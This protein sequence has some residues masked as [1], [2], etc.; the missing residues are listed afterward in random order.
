MK[1]EAC[2]TRDRWH[3][4]PAIL[5]VCLAT[6]CAPK[7][8]VV[9]ENAAAQ[10]DAYDEFAL[11]GTHNLLTHDEATNPDGTVNVVVEIPAGTTAKWEV[12]KEDGMLRWEFRDGKPRRVAYLA[13]PANYGMIPRTLLPE[14]EGGDGDPLDAVVLGPALSRGSIA[15]G[16]LIGV[17]KL[18]DGG[19][20]DDKLVVA[21]ANTVFAQVDSLMALDASFPGVTT[22]LKTWFTNYKGPGAMEW[23]GFGDAA[24]AGRLLTTATMAYR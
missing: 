20:Q 23:L 6:A 22:I 9:L 18:L 19:E 21:S 24:E 11:V 16:R 13:Y 5:L 14:E 4:I 3:L 10:T 8:Q 12:S 1:P 17:L 7:H 2:N 15:R